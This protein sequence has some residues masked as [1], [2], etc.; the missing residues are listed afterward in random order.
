MQINNLGLPPLGGV[1][2]YRE[3]SRSG[4]SVDENTELLR[5][6]NYV[7]ARLV[8]IAAAHLSATPEWEIKA[9]L[10]HHMW[11]D[12]EHSAAIR[13][14]VSEMREPPLRLDE[15]PDPALEAWLDEAIRAEGSVEL[16]TGLYGVI[17]PALTKALGEHLEATNPLID[18]PTVRL[19][20]SILSEED[21]MQD[22]GRQAQDALPR[23]DDDR[24]RAAAWRD[25][26]AAY[27]AAA[28]GVSGRAVRHESSL[29]QSRADGRPYE[30]DLRPRR[31]ER[32]EDVYNTSEPAQEVYTDENREPD[33]RMFALIY[34][35]VREMGVPEYLSGVMART[36]GKP[37]EYYCDLA[38]QVWDEARHALMGEVA[39]YIHGLPF[40]RYPVNIHISTAL[41]RKEPLEVHAILWSVEQGLMPKNTGKHYEWRLAQAY[42][43]PFCIALQ[44]YDWADEVLHAQI[45]RRWLLEEF[46]SRADLQT[47][48]EKAKARWAEEM[49]KLKPLSEHHYWWDE[50]VREMRA[51][52]KR[53]QPRND[54]PLGVN[55]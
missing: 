37:W 22:W 35:R 5:R 50:Y 42:G 40:Y 36:P 19:I 26:L 18:H 28:G 48:C 14:R 3:A 21:E 32:F 54:A 47:Y 17:R 7:K 39:L 23:N 30:P 2:T 10:S 46:E 33:E 55:A 25:H 29:P 20:K 6:Y 34:K 51:G 43:E 45:G 44:D 16:I 41:N 4:L 27:L 24:Q 38:R 15:V 9:G 53:W 13:R 1:C 8:E 49:E 31:D 11:L 12:S 52:E